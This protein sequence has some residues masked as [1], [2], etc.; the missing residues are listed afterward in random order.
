MG[1]VTG[2][3]TNRTDFTL[4]DHLGIRV[5]K[6]EK[7]AF[8]ECS[9][10]SDDTLFHYHGPSPPKILVTV[11]LN[12]VADKEFVEEEENVRGTRK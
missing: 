9:D 5:R 4:F 12:L 3:E 8:L 6:R 7:E 11:F 1:T 2:D 10:V